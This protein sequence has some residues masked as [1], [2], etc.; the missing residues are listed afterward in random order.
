M[1]L[2]AFAT[3]AALRIA[4]AQRTPTL[5]PR[6]G[7]V[8][9][10]SARLAPGVWRLDAPA[11]VDSALILVRGDDVT[12]DLT[13]VTLLG[14]DSLADPDRS[15]G[16]AIR[17]DGGRHVRIRGARVRGYKVGILARGT[18]DLVLDDNDLSHNW[19]PRLYSEVEH[20]SLADWLSFHH[21]E[22]DEWLRYGAAIYL[23]D[24]RGGA[25]RGNT[26][27]QGMNGLMMTRTDSVRVI[28]NDFSF[29]SGLGIGLYRSSFNTIMHNRVD[30]DVRGYSDGFYHRGQDSAGLL[31][32]EQSCDNVVAFNSVTHGGDGLFLWAGQSTMDTGAGGAND[33]LFYANDFSFAPANGIEATFSRNA[34][35]ANRISGNDY[36]V[37]GGY[38]FNSDI[39]ANHFSNNRVGIAIEHGQDNLIRQNFF[40]GDTTAI[41]LWGNPIE[42]SDWGYPKHRDTRSRDY[43]IRENLFRHLRVGLR[44]ANTSAVVAHV[45]FMLMVDS[46]DVVRDSPGYS[47]DSV[48]VITDPKF[49]MAHAGEEI[50]SEWL[51]KVPRPVKGAREVRGSALAVAPRSAIVVDEWGPY[52][53]RSPKLWPID[54]VRAARIRLQ[55]LGPRGTWRLVT[56]NGVAAVSDSSGTVPDTVT[57]TRRAGSADDW[58]VTLEYRGAETVSPR[59]VRR[60]SGAPVRFSFARSE[61][62]ID[63]SARF[64]AWSDSTDPRTKPEAF[65]ALID[66]GKS[67][68]ELSPPRLDY[69]WYQPKIKGVPQ[70]RFAVHAKGRVSLPEGSSYELRAISD[71]G[72]RVWLDGKLVID[73]WAPHESDAGVD[74]VAV[75]AGAHE[76]EVQYYQVDG[77]TELRVEIARTSSS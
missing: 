15:S 39:A 11:S 56:S 53:W 62:R 48:R 18:R 55:V 20:E 30:Y 73:H 60:A 41:S 34:F 51:Q 76:L 72:V 74:R 24:V 13:G 19:K 52:D 47:L 21:N 2:V 6:V 65:R 59:G 3:I 32:Y 22:K 10:H 36:G 50:P 54:S 31:M 63:W 4:G 67:L 8:L 71:D 58:D 33:N 77:W 69:V 64:F 27:E 57:I 70:S 40:F 12:V 9:T 35:V 7:L 26:V 28:A 44:L 16:V 1:V 14:A 68:L 66:S 37:W 46:V 75:P 17:V 49:E 43:T 45:N 29:N 5:Q 25:V 61:P 38:S 42:P 23:V